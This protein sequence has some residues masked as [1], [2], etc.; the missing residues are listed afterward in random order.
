MVYLGA[1]ID[2]CTKLSQPDLQVVYTHPE[3]EF[4][5]TV[6]L[7]AEIGFS[8]SS[9]DLRE[10]MEKLMNMSPETNVAIAIDMKETPKY[11]NPL[12]KE[13]VASVFRQE[14]QK[15]PN[16]T[17]LVMRFQPEDPSDAH[18]PL[19][20]SGARWAGEITATVQVWRRDKET[21]T[22]VI[23]D[24]PVVRIKTLE[25]IEIS[26]F[27]IQILKSLIRF[28]TEKQPRQKTQD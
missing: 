16:S 22:S 20:L 14:H 18:S 11:K 5:Q 13:K 9:E 17:P 8:Q 3:H 2:A 28:S 24:D 4:S 27:L 10:R 7:V 21:K 26:L 15:E 12:R 19:V 25:V 1:G 23:R 6:V